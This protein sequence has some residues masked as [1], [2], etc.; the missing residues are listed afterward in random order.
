MHSKSNRNQQL[1]RRPGTQAFQCTSESACGIACTILGAE[2]SK[3]NITSD[4]DVLKCV[5]GCNDELSAT[6][7]PSCVKAKITSFTEIKT[8][9][10]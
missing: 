4:F 1:N 10:D 3:L 6:L 7:S 8:S 2:L 5:Q 9:H